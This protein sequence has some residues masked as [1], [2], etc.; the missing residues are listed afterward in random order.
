MRTIE[1]GKHTGKILAN[2]PV[3]YLDWASKHEKNFAERNRWVSR[4]AKIIL[5]RVKEPC[6]PKEKKMAKILIET[7]SES[8]TT[9]SASVIAKYVG[10]PNDGKMMYEVKSLISHTK[11]YDSNNSKKRW[12]ETIFELPEGTKFEIIGK[13]A[14]GARGADKHAFHKVFVVDSSANV[15]ETTIDVGLR[16]ADLKGRVRVVKDALADR[17]R[18]EAIARTEGF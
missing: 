4:D 7:G 16:D 3:E 10:G 8:H 1:S 6:K 14:T 15:L 18:K 2:C 9:S 12:V 5:E 13:G 11:W 17:E